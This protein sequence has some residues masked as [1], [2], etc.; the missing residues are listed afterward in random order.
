[1]SLNRIP[2]QPEEDKTLSIVPDKSS[3][4]YHPFNFLAVEYGNDLEKLI[5]RIKVV[6]SLGLA[7]NFIKNEKIKVL[8][9]LF[10]GIL[11]AGL[12]ATDFILRIK[13]YIGGLKKGELSVYG[14]KTLNIYKLLGIKET[15]PS[16]DDL[17]SREAVLS[18]E[19]FIWLTNRPN[20]SIVKII[21]YYNLTTL[22]E[23]TEVTFDKPKTELAILLEYKGIKI[24]YDLKIKM[25]MG[26]TTL[27]NSE[28]I[29]VNI[30]SSF[31]LELKKD[32]MHEYIASLDT[33]N[34]ALFIDSWSCIYAKPRRKVIERINQFDVDRLIKEIREVLKSKRRR[35]F[36]FVGKPGVG[37]SAILRK[38]EEEI[39]EFMV[40]HL[41]SDDFSSSRGLRERFNLIR[42]FQPAIVIIED[43]DACGL[44]EKTPITGE[45][46]NCI[47]EIN[48]DLNIV[49]VVSVNDTSSVHY[50]VLNRP[51]RFDRI[52]EIVTPTSID[53]VQEVVKSK[54]RSISPNYSDKKIDADKFIERNKEMDA[55]LNLLM[56]YKFTQ[57]EITNAVVEQAFIDRKIDIQDKKDMLSFAAYMALSIKKHLKTKE[58]LHNCDFSNESPPEEDCFKVTD[59][60]ETSSY[61]LRFP[62]I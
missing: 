40:I 23:I 5:S 19:L 1:M 33:S 44:R 22:E 11:T 28:I 45:F 7:S 27:I 55:V 41:Q 24:V 20:T 26:S 15:D 43:L 58:A 10:T 16:V 50:T 59:E 6:L 37:K 29:G 39:R 30:D 32:L 51:G 31:E 2:S 47:D 13:S 21:G 18:A 60:A 34:N 38:I 17:C 25:W 12:F 36:A 52:F 48:K 35:A 46:L 3:K 56:N 14:K 57:A 49:I 9:K 42:T 8:I 53:E 54:V 62:K 61:P 4:F